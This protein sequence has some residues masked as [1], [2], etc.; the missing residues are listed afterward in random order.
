MVDATVT[1]VSGD[2]VILWSVGG[3]RKFKPKLQ[4]IA[5][6]KPIRELWE[7]EK[8]REPFARLRPWEPSCRIP[9]ELR[10]IIA[11]N[12]SYERRVEKEGR[13]K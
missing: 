7:N 13:F 9:E 2:R 1:E 11:K 6:G 3:Q 10:R 5:N 8:E 4:Q 12:D